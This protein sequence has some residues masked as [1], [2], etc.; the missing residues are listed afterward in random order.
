MREYLYIRPQAGYRRC[1]SALELKRIPNM[2]LKQAFPSNWFKAQD[3]P[4]EGLPVK[5]DKLTYE[6]IGPDQDQ[7]LV[8]WFR[9]QDKKLVLNKT[10]WELIAAALNQG[11]SDQWVGK[12]IELFSTQTTFSGK[13]VDCIRV[14]RYRPAAQQTPRPAPIQPVPV[15]A[16]DTP[17]EDDTPAVTDF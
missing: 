14:R 7:K 13:R 1:V 15:V 5:I 4:P 12:S 2:L 10:N 6:R 17:W 3:I 8:L 11:D 16:Q 9:N